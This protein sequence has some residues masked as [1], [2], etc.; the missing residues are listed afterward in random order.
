MAALVYICGFAPDAGE[1]VNTLI[2]G[3]PSD[4]LDG[5]R[6]GGQPLGLY[7]AAGLTGQAAAA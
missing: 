4:V 7:L 5:D 1:S 6:G 3:F 2:T